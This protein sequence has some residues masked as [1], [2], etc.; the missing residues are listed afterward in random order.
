MKKIFAVFIMMLWF[1]YAYTQINSFYVNEDMKITIH[2][3]EENFMFTLKYATIETKEDKRDAVLI[4]QDL[5]D[6]TA[7]TILDPKYVPEI[8]EYMKKAYDMNMPLKSK[9][10]GVNNVDFY[11][12]SDDYYVIV[13]YKNSIIIVPSFAIPALYNDLYN[14]IMASK[15]N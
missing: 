13:R 14:V 7:F 4:F 5:G 3:S 11:R 8:A 15:A 6:N 9:E 2:V 1:V 12:D 10:F